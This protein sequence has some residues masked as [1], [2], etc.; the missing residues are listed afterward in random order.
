M[1]SMLQPQ[2]AERTRAAITLVDPCCLLESG[3][4]VESIVRLHGVHRGFFSKLADMPTVRDGYRETL[5]AV[6]GAAFEGFIK[7]RLLVIQR[8]S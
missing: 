2:A 8:V 4:S 6:I 5:C 7:E 1:R 3:L